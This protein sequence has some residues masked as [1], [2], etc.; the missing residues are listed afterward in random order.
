[1]QLPETGLGLAALA[2]LAAAIV[3]GAITAF[4]RIAEKNTPFDIGLLHGRAGAFA[5]ILLALSVFIGNEAAPSIKPALGL[6]VLTVLAGTA[7]YYLIRR[8][9][10]L[11]K[12]VIFIHG[13][14]AV[15]AVYTLL[16]GLP[17]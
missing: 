13:G 16:F 3:G 11:P 14:L 5:A 15:T 9:G 12:S 10:V 4:V 2:I 7:L 17:F 1:M 8:K 6:L